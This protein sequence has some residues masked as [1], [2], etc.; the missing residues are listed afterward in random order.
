MANVSIIV[1]IYNVEKY[2]RTC[3]ES[4]INQTYD[5][6]IIYA[7]NDGSPDNSHAIMEEYGI[8]YPNKFVNIYKENGGYGSVLEYAIKNIESPYFLICDPDDYISND[9][10]EI[11]VNLQKKNESDLTIGAKTLIYSDDSASNYDISYNSEYVKLV[12]EKCY[13][14]SEQDYEK[15]FFI[16]P[17]PHSKLYKTS[18]FKDIT[19]PK[20]VGYTDNLLFYMGLI[21]SNKVVYTDKPLS[22]YLIDRAGNTMT[23]FNPKVIDAHVKVFETIINNAEKEKSTP[24]IFYYRMFESYKFIFQYLKKINGKEEM[25]NDKSKVIYQLVIRLRKHAQEIKKYYE[26]YSKSLANERKKDY[27]LLSCFSSIIYK[28]EVKKIHDEM[29]NY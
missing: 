22:Y 2:L 18:M 10:L 5:D 23:D 7:V 12:N 1:P 3:F 25:L 27:L 11:L 26:K 13:V 6:Y 15:L 24:D 4:L 20:K 28:Y 16:D 9:T 17:S 8:K 29:R 14:H 19:F 21:R